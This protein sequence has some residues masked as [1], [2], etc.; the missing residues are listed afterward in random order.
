MC[1]QGGTRPEGTQGA[2]WVVEGLNNPGRLVARPRGLL[3]EGPRQEGMRAQGRG[4]GRVTAGAG[5]VGRA[6]MEEAQ[7]RD[8][9]KGLAEVRD[10]CG[11]P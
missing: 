1:E 7:G 10:A 4:A 2:P 5:V 11:L 8:D 3:A 9:A 6:T